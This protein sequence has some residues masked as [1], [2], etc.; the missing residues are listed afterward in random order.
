MNCTAV[1]LCSQWPLSNPDVHCDTY[2]PILSVALSDRLT[3][4]CFYEQLGC[5]TAPR[6][7]ERLRKLLSLP[8]DLLE[9]IK[10]RWVSLTGSSFQIWSCY[11]F[12][13][14]QWDSFCFCVAVSAAVARQHRAMAEN[15]VGTMRS[16][17]I[18]GYCVGIAIE[19]WMLSV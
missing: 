7:Q 8:A 5:W 15:N 16:L 6:C 10:L 19:F 12:Q 4:L 3:G 9:K 11:R 2:L 18:D 17:Y 13:M 14:K 1:N